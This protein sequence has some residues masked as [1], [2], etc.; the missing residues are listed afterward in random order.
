MRNSIP[1]PNWNL[2]SKLSFDITRGPHKILTSV[3]TQLHGEIMLEIEMVLSAALTQ[4]K[5]PWHSQKEQSPTQSQCKEKTQASAIHP[6]GIPS[7]L[8]RSQQHIQP[9]E[10]PTSK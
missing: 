2:Y 4:S 1:A 6:S 3:L 7:T 5:R 10:K 9:S 8:R